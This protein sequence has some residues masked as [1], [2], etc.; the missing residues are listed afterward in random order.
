MLVTLRKAKFYQERLLEVARS[1]QTNPVVQLNIFEPVEQ[2]VEKAHSEFARKIDR[3]MNLLSAAYNIRN[4]ISE[5]NSKS[6][7]NELLGK[8][9]M[10]EKQIQLLQFA[11][12][13]SERPS[14]LVINGLI[15]T[16]KNNSASGSPYS[17]S[18]LLSSTVGI[19]TDEDISMYKSQLADLHRNKN[20]AQDELLDINSRVKIQ[21]SS[22]VVDLLSEEDLI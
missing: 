9:A 15:N 12:D 19:L 14:H 4:L 7:V 2:Q 20:L 11:Q 16:I 18:G 10:Y 6:G 17:A 22:A 5:K 8:I 1:S 21:L 3:K 13:A